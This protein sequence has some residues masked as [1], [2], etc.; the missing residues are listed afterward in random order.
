MLPGR[1]GTIAGARSPISVATPQGKS[2][3]AKA[4][5]KE[6]VLA[7]GSPSEQSEEVGDSPPGSQ[8]ALAQQQLAAVRLR[9]LVLVSRRVFLRHGPT[10]RGTS[11]SF[12][13][14]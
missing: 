4:R 8:R 10:F 9:N 1:P 11:D 2:E 3:G 7:R 12:F 14:T 5:A 13:V 6:I